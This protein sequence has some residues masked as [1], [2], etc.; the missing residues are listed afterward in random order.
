MAIKKQNSVK[1]LHIKTGDT[2]LVLSGDDKG[3]KGVVKQIIAEKYRA[4]VEG[5]NKVKRH[6]KP[7]ADQ[8]GG[9]VE[10]EAS[11]HI[12][13]LMLVDAEGTASRIKIEVRDGKKVRV[14]KKTNNIIV[15]P[16]EAQKEQKN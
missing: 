10:R 12:S 5:L 11:M 2:V 7:S 9:I 1:K 14:S 15:H 3:K 13:N 6:V 8:P 16:F 4:I